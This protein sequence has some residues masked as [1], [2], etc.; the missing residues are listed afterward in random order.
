MQNANALARPHGFHLRN[1]T[2]TLI[3]SLHQLAEVG[4]VIQRPGIG[5][6][7]HVGDKQPSLQ[8]APFTDHSRAFE[9]GLGGINTE[10]IIRQFFDDGLAEL[11]PLNGDDD[12]SLAPGQ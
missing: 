4:C 1:H 6:I 7:L 12:I 2:A 3:M 11:W 10:R 5:D 8:I 9:I